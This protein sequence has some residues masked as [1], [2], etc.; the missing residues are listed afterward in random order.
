MGTNHALGTERR[1]W[2]FYSGWKSAGLR[3]G[4]IQNMSTLKYFRIPIPFVQCEEQKLTAWL[5]HHYAYRRK[6]ASTLQV[7]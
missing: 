4:T 2:T 1:S 3:Q 6:F 7:I 5:V